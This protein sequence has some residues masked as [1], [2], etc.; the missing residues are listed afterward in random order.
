MELRQVWTKCMPEKLQPAI[1]RCTYDTPLNKL[2][3][4]ADD[5]IKNWQEDEN[6]SIESIK[7]EARRTINLQMERLARM[8]ESISDIFDQLPSD[9]QQ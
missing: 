2:A 4:S 1:E 3:D 6:R 7:E 8:F 9:L 5:W